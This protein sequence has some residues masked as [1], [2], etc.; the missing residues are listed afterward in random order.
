VH[1]TVAAGVVGDA[2]EVLADAG[3]DSIRLA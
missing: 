3:Y 1:V 2:T